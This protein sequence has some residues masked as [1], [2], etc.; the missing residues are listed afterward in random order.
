[1]KQ[2]ASLPSPPFASGAF[3]ETESELTRGFF[4]FIE[5]TEVVEI[6]SKRLANQE[7]S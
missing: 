6:V 3:V 7:L 4:R 5:K 1:M 2:A